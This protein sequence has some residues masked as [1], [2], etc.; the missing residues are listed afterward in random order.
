MNTQLKVLIKNPAAHIVGI[1]QA[2]QACPGMMNI[3]KAYSVFNILKLQGA[4]LLVRNCMRMDP[5]QGCRT[6]SFIQKD[7]G[8]IS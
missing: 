7:V 4:I 6:P 5:S 2:D 1:F 3:I 8:F